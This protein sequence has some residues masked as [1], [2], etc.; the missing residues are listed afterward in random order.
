MRGY[1]IDIQGTLIDDKDFLP[2][3]G[4]REFID[5][6]NDKKIPYVL[7][8]NN[9]KRES[10]EFIE[11]LKSIGFNIDKNHYIDPL[12]VLKEKLKDITLKP[13]GNEKFVEIIRKN[14]KTSLNPEAV[15]LG[16]KKYSMDEISE[17]IELLLNGAKLYGMHK[18]SLYVKDNKRYP[19]LGALLEMLKFA[20]GK[21]YEVFGKPSREFFERAKEK[22]KL[23]F[24]KITIISDDLRGDLLPANKLGMKA[25]LVLSGKIKNINEV[26]EKVDF[27][28]KNIGEFLKREEF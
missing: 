17:I 19:G 21:S 1:F 6:L 27:I 12:M 23:N 8:T 18:T 5:Y 10:D 16:I 25:A 20:T 15:I 26:N 24:D 7:I 4:A 13:F 3:D 11:Y 22:I 9:T 14:Y 2:I 28:A